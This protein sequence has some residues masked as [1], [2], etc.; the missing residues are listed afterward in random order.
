MNYPAPPPPQK[1]S[2]PVWLIVILITIPAIFAIVG[3]LAVMGIYGTRKYIANA[4][5][6]EA[7]NSI[8]QIAKD[9]AAAYERDGKLCPSA[10]SPI[11]AAVPH[12]AKYQSSPSEWEADKLSNAGFSC[13][14]FSMDYPQYYQYDYKSTPTGFT[15]TAHGDLNGD[16]VI[17]TFEIEGQVIGGVV[18]IAPTIKETSPEE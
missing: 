4:K 3:I 8:A 1:S 18:S 17:S 7:R 6:A 12:A 11:P 10:S 14:K 15:V 5:T 9:A 13:L 2:F 16:G